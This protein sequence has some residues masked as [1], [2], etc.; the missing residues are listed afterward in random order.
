MLN[1]KELYCIVEDE[2]NSLKISKSP[3]KLYDPISY[4]MNIGGK[5]MRA[6]IKSNFQ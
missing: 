3:K 6:I 5:R 1:I 2:I 4:I